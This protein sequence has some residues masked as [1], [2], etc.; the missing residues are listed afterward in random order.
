MLTVVAVDKKH[1]KRLNNYHIIE[2][3]TVCFI[4]EYTLQWYIV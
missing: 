4:D 3:K 2:S 1:R